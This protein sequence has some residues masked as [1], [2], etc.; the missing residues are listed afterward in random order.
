MVYLSKW[1]IPGIFFFI[2]LFISK[3]IL[4]KNT[5]GLVRTLVPWFQQ[6]PLCLN[7]PFLCYFIRTTI[8]PGSIPQEGNFLLRNVYNKRTSTRRKMFQSKIKHQLAFTVYKTKFTTNVLGC[9]KWITECYLK[10]NTLI[11][12]LQYIWY[13]QMIIG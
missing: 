8:I 1:A 11:S 13:Y 7:P 6:R 10:A 2:F 12:I 4:D 3:Q 9:T 5:D